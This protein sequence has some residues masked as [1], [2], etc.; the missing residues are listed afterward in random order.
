ME[1]ASPISKLIQRAE[2]YAKTT[3]TLYKLTMVQKSADIVSGIVSKLLLLL[4]MA[5]FLLM[6][7]LGASLWIGEMLG[8]SY[9]GFFIVT[10]FYLLLFILLY[11]FRAQFI[12]SPTR[13][14]VVVEMLKKDANEE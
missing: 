2:D 4:V 13:N 6:L 11:I 5:F 8:K 9:Y 7:S 14:A 10:A 12:V 3:L 1:N